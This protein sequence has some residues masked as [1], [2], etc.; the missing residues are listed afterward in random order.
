MYRVVVVKDEGCDDGGMGKE[1]IEFEN[2]VFP[3]SYPL[4]RA[5]LFHVYH[6]LVGSVR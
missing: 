3:I 6:S 1:G 4:R 2:G 5:L